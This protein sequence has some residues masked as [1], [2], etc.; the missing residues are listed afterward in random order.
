M[1]ISVA[2]TLL[3]LGAI[4]KTLAS[5]SSIVLTS[6]RPS[7]SACGIVRGDLGGGNP[8]RCGDRC[9]NRGRWLPGGQ[10]RFD[11]AAGSFF[12]GATRVANRHCG[13]A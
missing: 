10:L 11:G 12:L 13:P 2:L 4:E 5:I 9:A 1:G 8:L 3:W 6:V 7:I